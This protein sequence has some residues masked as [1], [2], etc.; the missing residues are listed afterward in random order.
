MT[1]DVLSL[2]SFPPATNDELARRFAVTHRVHQ[3]APQDLSDELRGR[4]SARS[5]PRPIAAR[6]AR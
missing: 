5:P 4:A 3:P 1:I 6:A 2:G